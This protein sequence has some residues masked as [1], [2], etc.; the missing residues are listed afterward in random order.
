[1]PDRTIHEMPTHTTAVSSLPQLH[2]TSTSQW[3]A[4]RLEAIP[5]VGRRWLV[6]GGGQAARPERVR[7]LDIRA[8]TA[9]RTTRIHVFQRPRL[10]T[11]GDVAPAP[12]SI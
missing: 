10:A 9:R 12:H 2:V 7:V 8:T 1:L 5:F 11:W 4:D 6:A 3:C